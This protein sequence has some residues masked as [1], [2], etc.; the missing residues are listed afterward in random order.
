MN[1]GDLRVKG[2]R[3][4]GMAWGHFYAKQYN[5]KSFSVRVLW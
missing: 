2:L 5:D 1:T 3:G 4:S